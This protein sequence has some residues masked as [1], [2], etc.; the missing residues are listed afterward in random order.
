MTNV[1][2]YSTA[3]CEVNGVAKAEAEAE[4]GYVVGKYPSRLF[5]IDN[6]LMLLRSFTR[7]KNTISLNCFNCFN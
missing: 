4:A 6:K 2:T 1:D 5:T 7:C 3:D